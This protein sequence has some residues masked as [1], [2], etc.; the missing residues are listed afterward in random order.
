MT[1]QI[2]TYKVSF[3]TP[4]FLGNAEQQGQWR[5]PPFKALLRQ[6]WRVVYATNRQFKVDVASM[7]REEG[8]LFGHAWL[9]S[10]IDRSGQKV[11]ARQ[12][13]IRLRMNSWE[14]GK[15]KSWAGDAQVQHPEVGRQVGAQLYMGFGPLVY[16]KNVG[17]TMKAGAAIQAGECAT[18]SIS[19]PKEHATPIEQAL[20]LMHWYGAVGGRSRNGWGSFALIPLGDWHVRA[21]VTPLRPWVDALTLDWPHALGQDES[22]PLIWKTAPV[23]DWQA[24]MKQLAAIK[25][26][27]RS[28][29]MY[30]LNSAVGDREAFD[31]QGRKV[32]I[33]H[34][35]PQDRHWLAYPV[36]HHNIRAWKVEGK[37]LRLP[38]SLRI[39]VRPTSEDPKRLIGVIFHVPCQPPPE[40]AP[41]R[42]AVAQTWQSVHLLL[43]ELTKPANTRGYASILDA[44]RRAKLK[45]LLDPVS[46]TRITE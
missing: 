1:M 35:G 22:G 46:L 10:D 31:K 38:N 17:T 19:A 33:D 24:L 6:W 11:A 39:K 42:N 20:A 27:L 4:A 18:F 36:T 5:T 13:L 34:G 15:L 32:G 28:Q 37:D 23:A 29:F 21:N 44:D 16:N 41:D 26:G 12:S 14:P 9:D 45:A 7:R 3:T 25:I 30:K 43:D 2:L 40:F 8:L